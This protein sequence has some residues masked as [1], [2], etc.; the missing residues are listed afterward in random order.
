LLSLERF[1]LSARLAP[2]APRWLGEAIVALACLALGG[3][4][5]LMLDALTPG[6]AP[7]VLLLPLVLVATVAGG[8]RPALA[9]LSIC[10][11]WTWFYVIPPKGLFHKGAASA[12]E[13]A[14][15]TV[16]ALLVIGVAQIFRSAAGR[17]AEA[18][19]AKLAERDLMLRELEH[20]MKNNFQTVA[21]LLELQL[22]RTPDEAAR[23]AL[24]Q[25]LNRVISVSQAHQSLQAAGGM[26]SVDMGVYLK[27]LCG[28]LAEALLLGELIRLECQA[29][30]GLLDRDRAVAVGLIVNE[31]VTNAAKHAFPEGRTGRIRVAFQRQ[32]TGY[33]LVV[34]DDGQGLPADFGADRRGLGRGLVEA[35]ARQAGGSISIGQGPGARF[36][37]DLTA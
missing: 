21:S 30:S 2:A 37:V 4:L 11:L 20:R 16:A 34:E 26:R 6:L 17:Q 22:R 35:F 14:A 31:L 32:G 8:W 29:E 3:V 1:D 10:E 5:R 7:F 25:A 23:E 9:T 33:R 36:E 28:S 27:D 12:A 13:L 24:R 19:A 15:V 18:G